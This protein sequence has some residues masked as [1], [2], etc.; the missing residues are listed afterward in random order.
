MKE[1]EYNLSYP[2]CICRPAND[3][4]HI[5]ACFYKDIKQNVQLLFF[6][7]CS[8]SVGVVD[9]RVVG[10]P[11]PEE[12]VVVVVVAWMLWWRSGGSVSDALMSRWRGARDLCWCGVRPAV[13]RTL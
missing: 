10:G 7:L 11:G 8:Y 4:S 5:P 9:G 3:V 6:C 13:G 1:P 12:E 2:E